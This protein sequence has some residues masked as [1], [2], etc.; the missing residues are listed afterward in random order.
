VS[1]W[2]SVSVLHGHAQ[3]YQRSVSNVAT[4]VDLNREIRRSRSV[5]QVWFVH[6]GHVH[7]ADTALLQSLTYNM[8]MNTVTAARRWTLVDSATI[9]RCS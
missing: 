8:R 2:A 9:P 1:G 7:V 4:D 5:H 3:D 6:N